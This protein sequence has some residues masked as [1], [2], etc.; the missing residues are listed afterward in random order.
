L[1]DAELP[2]AHQK[3]RAR[4]GP[5]DR[6]GAPR[7]HDHVADEADRRS[8]QVH[9]DRRRLSVDRQAELTEAPQQ[10][11]RDHPRRRAV[12]KDHRLRRAPKCRR[13]RDESDRA[14]RCAREGVRAH[15]RDDVDAHG[16]AGRKVA[17]GSS[18]APGVHVDVKSAVA[19]GRRSVIGCARHGPCLVCLTGLSGTAVEMLG[20]SHADVDG[21]TVYPLCR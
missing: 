13:I 11:A 2:S 17:V 14:A 21:R 4:L 20:A 5:L 15:F 18:C 7:A 1:L 12:P 16:G 10:D 6:Q 8:G 9:S 19:A 3:R